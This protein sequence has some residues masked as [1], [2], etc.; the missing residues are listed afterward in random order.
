MV[1]TDTKYPF[2]NISAME[3]VDKGILMIV[4]SHSSAWMVLA[5]DN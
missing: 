4:L 1:K 3:R 2:W 5:E